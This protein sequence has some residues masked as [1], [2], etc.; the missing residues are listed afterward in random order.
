PERITVALHKPRGVV[1]TRS[2]PEGRP[3]VV[4]LV[5]IPRARLYP[6]GR[7]DYAAEGLIFLTNDGDLAYTLLRPGSAE[8]VYQVKVK[9]NPDDDAL[10][11]LRDGV[12]LSGKRTLPARVSRLGRGTNGWV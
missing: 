3:T 12:S 4:E 7:L 6:I 2:D 5:R 10:A 1:S 8:R 9:G 11:K